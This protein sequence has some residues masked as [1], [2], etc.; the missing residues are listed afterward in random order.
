MLSQK[1]EPKEKA[2]PAMAFGFPALLD[3]PSGCATRPDS[4]QNSLAIAELKQC[5]P[6]SL[7]LF[8]LLGMAAGVEAYP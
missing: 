5:S 2:A 7:G 3:K 6:K 4:Q 8:A 1:K